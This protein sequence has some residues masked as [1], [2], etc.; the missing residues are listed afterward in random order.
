VST[1]PH[2]PPSAADAAYEATRALILEGTAAP[3]SML[4]EGDVATQLGISRTPVREAFL[5]LQA[6]GWLRLYPKRGALVVPPAP[7]EGRD[8]VQAR[9]L[10]ETAS[11]RT[12]A[13]LLDQGGV[14]QE[15]LAAQLQPHVDAQRAAHEADDFTEFTEA[16][17]R[18]HRALVAAAGN[19]VLLQFQDSLADRERRM[20]ARSLWGRRDWAARTVDQHQELLDA[21]LAG[22][23]ERFETLLT[24]HLT[25]THA[26][27]IA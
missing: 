6:E 1:P 9:I 21:V 11:A 24:H 14:G 7:N 5:R 27:Q 12:L 22:D 3:N 10:I 19:A 23:P 15:A 26:E 8:V 13:Q 2:P 4:S 16:D 18:F 20:A 25:S 17:L